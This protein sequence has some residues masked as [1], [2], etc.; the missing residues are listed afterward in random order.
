[1]VPPPWPG[2]GAQLTT[3][4]DTVNA[5]GADI[6]VGRVEPTAIPLELARIH[7]QFERIHPFLD[8]NG[9]TG[10]LVLNLILVRLGFPPAIVFK[11]E[12]EG[13]LKGLDQADNG[14]PGRLAEQLARS[15][16]DNLHRLVVPNIAGP[17]RIVPLRSLVS[18]D[19]SF[20]AL[21][22]AARR[23]ALEAHQGSDGIWRSST[24]LDVA[25]TFADSAVREA[26]VLA[27]SVVRCSCGAGH[28]K[29]GEFVRSDDLQHEDRADEGA[30]AEGGLSLP[31]QKK[32]ARL[33]K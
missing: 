15:V 10:R 25:S 26:P 31:S 30:V 8:G 13:Y 14:D 19:L 24:G 28:T 1:M 2:V 21:R 18:E 11:R 16:I 23:G 32:E 9:R 20:E 4:A 5:I 29:L 7:N 22:Q 6:A 3:W 27:R 17:S 33:S 12:S